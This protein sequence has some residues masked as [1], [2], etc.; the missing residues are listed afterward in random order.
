MLVGSDGNS[1]ELSVLVFLGE[2]LEDAFVEYAFLDEFLEAF[3]LFEAAVELDVRVFPE[4]GA[5][6]DLVPHPFLNYRVPNL[7]KGENIRP[8]C[9]LNMF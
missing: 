9:V 5:F 4:E 6:S 3:A 8:V 2:D 7:L 1:C